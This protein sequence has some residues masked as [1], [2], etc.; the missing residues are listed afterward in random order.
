MPSKKEWVVDEKGYHA[1]SAWEH[2]PSDKTVVYLDDPVAADSNAENDNNYEVEL[3]EGTWHE[4]EEGFQFNKKCKVWVKANFLKETTRKK[5]T[6]DTYIIYNDEE[7]SLGQQVETPLNDDGIAEAEVMLYYGDKY[8]KALQQDPNAQCQYKFKANHSTAKTELESELLEMPQSPSITF[9]EVEILSATDDAQENNNLRIVI[10]SNDEVKKYVYKE[11]EQELTPETELT[12]NKRITIKIPQSASQP[13]FTLYPDTQKRNEKYDIPLES[14]IDPDTNDPVKIFLFKPLSKNNTHSPVLEMEGDTSYLNGLNF[15]PVTDDDNDLLFAQE[16]NQKLPIADG[17]VSIDNLSDEQC[18]LIVKELLGDDF[19]EQ[20]DKEKVEEGEKK[21]YWPKK[22]DVM[23]RDILKDFGF[24]GK[25]YLKT[26]KGKQHVIFRGYSGLR[27]WYTGT[28]YGVKNMRVLSLS[29]AGKLKS[30]L[31]GSGLALVVVGA[32]DIFEWMLNEDN[33]KQ[34]ED[35]IVTLGIDAAK[36]VIG[37]IITAGITATILVF[38]GTATLPVFAVIVG[39]ITIG[40][41]VGFG[42][43]LLDNKIGASEY[44]KGK[45][46]E[47]SSMLEDTWNEHVVERFGKL[48]YQLEK[49]VENLYFRRIRIRY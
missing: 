31:K 38:L 42:L 6:I 35:L 9:R 20:L 1:K 37:G 3:L 36:I 2:H 5:V 10:D 19:E 11:K 18:E 40:V 28:R 27:K 44:M 32:I 34:V 8:S 43:D 48:Y 49:S 12:G 21:T 46:R 17:P 39:S 30:G 33:D 26:T 45:G 47:A 41:F 24:K 25:F 14:F 23:T 13:V 7:E 16:M 29:A 15:T 4:G 22:K